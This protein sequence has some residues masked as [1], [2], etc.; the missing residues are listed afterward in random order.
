MALFDHP[1]KDKIFPQF[2]SMKKGKNIGIQNKS[3]W[4]SDESVFDADYE[5]DMH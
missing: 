5:Y 1:K 2:F 3:K 4:G